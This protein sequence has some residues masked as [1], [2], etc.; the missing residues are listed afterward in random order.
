MNEETGIHAPIVFSVNDKVIQEVAEEFKEVDAYKDLAEAKAAKKVLTKMRS[1]L[2]EAHKAAKA[3]ALEYGRKCDAEKNRLL[4]QIKVIEDP[5]T[6]QLTEIKEAEERK[7]QERL[8]KIQAA[9]ERIEAHAADRYSLTLDQLRERQ[10]NLGNIEITE[11]IFQEFT[12]RAELLKQDAGMKL[13]LAIKAEKDRIQEEAEKAEREE[14]NRRLKEKIDAMER[15]Q[16]EQR[17]KEQ[18]KAAEE[19][20]EAQRKAD[21]KAELERKAREKAEDEARKLREEKEERERQEAAEQA[22]KEAEERALAQAP[23][24]EKLLTFAAKVDEL[25]KGKP[26]LATEE[27][28]EVLRQAEAMLIE[29]AYDIRKMTEEMK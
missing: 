15:E 6:E 10:E 17:R 11:E 12:D 14:E 18:A 4:E 22:R 24:R 25:L 13:D 3:D 23:D 7:E 28:R 16:E 8:D 21:I 5:I 1:K 29:V 27:A 9:L 20:A 19:A 26:E 2:A